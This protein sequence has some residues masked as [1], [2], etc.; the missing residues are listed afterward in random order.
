MVRSTDSRASAVPH[1]ALVCFDAV[2]LGIAKGFDHCAI[3][4]ERS[5]NFGNSVKIALMGGGALEVNHQWD[6]SLEFEVAVKAYIQEYLAEDFHYFS[7]LMPLWDLQVAGL[8]AKLCG[9][10]LSQ[11]ISCNQ[12]TLIKG[13]ERW[14]VEWCK[15]CDKCCFVFAVLAAFLGP[16]KVAVQVFGGANLLNDMSLLTRFANLAGLRMAKNDWGGDGKPFECVG[17]AEEVRL[18]LQRSSCF[19]EEAAVLTELRSDLQQ[20]TSSILEDWGDD[21]NLPSWWSITPQVR[22]WLASVNTD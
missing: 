12:R 9:P 17:T 1:C 8:F 5:T 21:T 4:C 19:G 7:P 15:R 11:C 16:R 6:K 18:A 10:A 3:G 20:I 2:V 14:G 13:E 22:H